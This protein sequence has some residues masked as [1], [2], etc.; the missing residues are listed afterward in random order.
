MYEGLTLADFLTKVC[1][2]YPNVETVI[3]KL[4]DYVS[5]EY[6]AFHAKTVSEHVTVIW[7]QQRGKTYQ[8]SR[9][10]NIRDTTGYER[11]VY[12]IWDIDALKD[13]DINIG[14]RIYKDRWYEWQTIKIANAA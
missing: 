6:K 9:V 4:T 14:Y 5:P 10:S 1:N 12:A 7:F 2:A 3:N 13:Y 11:Y 8:V